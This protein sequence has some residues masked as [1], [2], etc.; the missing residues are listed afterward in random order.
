MAGTMKKEEGKVKGGVGVE[1]HDRGQLI[2]TG[3]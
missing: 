1:F 2:L 3:G